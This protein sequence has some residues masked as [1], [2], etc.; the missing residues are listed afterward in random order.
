M[1]R[2]VSS[3]EDA[4]LPIAAAHADAAQAKQRRDRMVE[5]I[6]TTRTGRALIGLIVVGITILALTRAGWTPGEVTHLTVEAARVFR[7]ECPPGVSGPPAPESEPWPPQ[8]PMGPE[9]PT[10]GP[11]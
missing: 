11:G 3:L 1:H 4:Y 6:T 10:D 2:R 7:G 9:S 8:D 5:G